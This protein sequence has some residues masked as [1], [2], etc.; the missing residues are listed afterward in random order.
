MP[1]RIREAEVFAVSS[2]VVRVV[3]APP[4]VASRS[5]AEACKGRYHSGRWY[6][7]GNLLKLPPIM[8]FTGTLPIGGWN[9]F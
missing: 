9:H 3:H 1:L 6:R 4:G 7:L 2:S 8:A 5:Y